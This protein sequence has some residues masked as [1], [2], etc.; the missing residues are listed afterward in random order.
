MILDIGSSFRDSALSD[1]QCLQKCQFLQIQRDRDVSALKF[2]LHSI[3]KYQRLTTG[4]VL[5]HFILCH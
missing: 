3:D 1:C 5:R 4:S 2:E